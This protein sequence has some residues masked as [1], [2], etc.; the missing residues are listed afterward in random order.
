MSQIANSSLSWAGRAGYASGNLGKSVVWSTLDYFFLFFLTQIWGLTPGEAGF[1]IFLS[2]V[3]DGLSDPLFGY[4]ADRTWTPLGKY[5]PYLIFGAPLC[6]L[7]FILLFQ[8]PG[9]RGVA[10]MWSVL[11]TSLLFRTCYTICDVPHNALFSRISANP[12]DATSISGLRFFFSSLGAL[13][14]SFAIGWAL[15]GINVEESASRVT[16][17]AA[18]AGAI[19]VISIWLAW[20]STR[21]LD[22]AL[23]NTART[24]PL[25]ASIRMTFGNSA[26]RLLLATAFVQA[27]SLP[28]FAKGIV[29]F[30][31][32]VRGDAAWAGEA[33]IILTSAQ[34][35]TQPAWIGVVRGMGK[36]RALRGAYLVIAVGLAV[37]ALA[38]G[39]PW[40]WLS[41]IGAGF[42]G[43]NMVLWSMLPDAISAGTTQDGVRVEAMPTGLFLLALK[44]GVG[45]SALL[46]GVGLSAI[47]LNAASPGDLAFGTDLAG[48][49][50]TIPITGILLLTVLQSQVFRV[51]S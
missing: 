18:I 19:Y 12:E 7:S 27:A 10:L 9:V 25:A 40:I 42:G 6:A 48:L 14:V 8:D 47:G 2:L 17:L 1:I 31:T 49:M 23:T 29:Y 20:A 22:V 30:A 44:S 13:I 38:P 3:W 43:A 4:V 32:F 24:T 26:M 35:L 50:I 51:R 37:F 34:A 28:A 16:T 21:R 36:D 45:L 33:L 11:S 15:A 5:G 39:L 46:V 41:V